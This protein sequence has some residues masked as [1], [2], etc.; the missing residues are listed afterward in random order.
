MS[1]HTAKLA[2]GRMIISLQSFDRSR[3]D[4]EEKMHVCCRDWL[5][6]TTRDRVTAAGRS[7]VDL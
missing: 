5:T 2:L 3:S 7:V 4:M 6:L 1:A